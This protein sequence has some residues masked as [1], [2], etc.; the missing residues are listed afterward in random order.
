VANLD[1]TGQKKIA[2]GGVDPDISPDGTKVAFNTEGEGT[3]RYIAV[4]DIASKKVTQFKGVP[5]DNSYGPV[6]LPDGSKLSFY[7]FLNKEWDIALINA[8][9]SGFR[10]LKKSEPNDHSYFSTA[11]MP[12]GRSFYCQDLENLY[13]VGLDGSVINQWPI[14]K[15]IKDGDMDSGMKFDVSPDGTHMLVENNG[16]AKDDVTPKG[17]D[18][19][20]PYILLMDLSE[21]AMGLGTPAFWWEPAWIDNTDFLC[22]HQGA[23][24]KQ[25]SIYRWTFAVKKPPVLLIKNATQPSVSR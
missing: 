8:D 21:D 4:V 22:I 6:W 15:L 20:A 19:P 18:G 1:G 17:W 2:T 13:H 11:W 14:Q 10:V 23:K 16:D 3:Q 5:S 9:G 25:P 24:E 12:D 7:I